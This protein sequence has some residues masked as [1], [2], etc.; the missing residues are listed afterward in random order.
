MSES[1]AKTPDYLLRDLVEVLQRYQSLK[2]RIL[3][4][5]Q[6]QEQARLIYQEAMKL[7]HDERISPRLRNCLETWV[8]KWRPHVRVARN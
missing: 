4:E 6:A 2:K 7:L 8:D 1:E 3:T 5:E